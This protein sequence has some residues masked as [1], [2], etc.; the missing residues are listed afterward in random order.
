MILPREAVERI[1]KSP[2]R[3]PVFVQELLAA[4]RIEQAKRRFSLRVLFLAA[5][6]FSLWATL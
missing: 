4:D 1:A 2:R 6:L 5:L 3:R